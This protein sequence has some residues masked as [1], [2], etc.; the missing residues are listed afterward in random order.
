[1]CSDGEVR[2][3]GEDSEREGQVEMCYNGVC[4]TVCADGWN[5]IA[6]NIVC[7]QLG[8]ENPGE[9]ADPNSYNHEV[10]NNL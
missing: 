4:G 6:A 9:L 1:M 2:L 8:Y 10:D 5:E 3:V 7:R